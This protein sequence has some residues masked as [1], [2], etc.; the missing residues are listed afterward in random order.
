MKN[1]RYLSP[2]S[3]RE[4]GPARTIQQSCIC[5]PGVSRSSARAFLHERVVDPRGLRGV[6]RGAL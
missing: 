5:V 2:V 1:N 4:T 3:T 6:W